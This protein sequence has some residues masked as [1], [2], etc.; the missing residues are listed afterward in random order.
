MSNEVTVFTPAT[1]VS[2]EDWQDAGEVIWSRWRSIPWLLATWYVY[3]EEHFPTLAIQALPSPDS[4]VALK[5]VKTLQHYSWG[6][7]RVPESVR[8]YDLSFSHHAAVASLSHEDQRKFLQV[9]KD[10]SLTIAELRQRIN[11]KLKR[12]AKSDRIAAVVDHGDSRRG[13]TWTEED[14]ELIRSQLG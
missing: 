9:A 10:E 1:P 6:V 8:D 14:A 5:E 3:G 2:F 12:Q 4:P 11:P 7:K 13:M